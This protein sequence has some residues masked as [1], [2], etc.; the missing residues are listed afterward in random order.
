MSNEYNVG[1]VFQYFVA[2][3]MVQANSEDEAIDLALEQ[4][5]LNEGFDFSKYRDID[6]ELIE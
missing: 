5:L 3:T 6:V 4:V 2:W 1:L